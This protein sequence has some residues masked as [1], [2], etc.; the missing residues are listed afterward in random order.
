MITSD[1][2][3]S[4]ALS[5][6]NALTQAV[7]SYRLKRVPKEVRKITSAINLQEIT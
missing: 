1:E 3:A 2:T 7:L 6:S 5:A 4:I